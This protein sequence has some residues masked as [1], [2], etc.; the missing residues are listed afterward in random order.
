M[1]PSTLHCPPWPARLLT[2]PQIHGPFKGRITTNQIHI[3][4]SAEANIEKSKAQLEKI[5]VSVNDALLEKVV[6]RLGIANQS[7]DASLVSATDP[8]EL[9]RVRT[10][11]VEKK[12]GLPS[13]DSNSEAV[14]EVVGKLAEFNQ[15]QRGAVYYL[16]TDKF[17]KQDV[18][19][20]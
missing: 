15:K 16:L 12:L 4:M 19:G 13:D 1:A 10:N 7:K 14:K 3:I 17:G 6:K 9:D 18:Y 20:V 2:T 5:G 11:F 8:S